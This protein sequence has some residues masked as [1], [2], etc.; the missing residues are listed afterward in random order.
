M[1]VPIFVVGKYHIILI[2]SIENKNDVL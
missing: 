2:L 1:G